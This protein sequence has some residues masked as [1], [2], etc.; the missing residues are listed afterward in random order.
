MA[1]HKPSAPV[2]AAPTEETP[3]VEPIAPPAPVPNSD[4][5]LREC[6]SEDIDVVRAARAG[7][8][9]RNLGAPQTKHLAAFIEERERAKIEGREPREV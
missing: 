5:W 4:H 6:S 8:K 1:K 9:F 3:D 7:E 2:E